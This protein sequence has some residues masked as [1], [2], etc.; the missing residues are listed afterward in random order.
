MDEGVRVND[1]EME[2]RKEV[3]EEKL[4]SKGGGVASAWLGRQS[5][6]R[7]EALNPCLARF[8]SLTSLH[9]RQHRSFPHLFH[10][11]FIHPTL[12]SFRALSASPTSVL[13]S[14]VNHAHARPA[15][16]PR[17]NQPRPQSRRSTSARATLLRRPRPHHH[18]LRS[19]R[20]PRS[21]LRQVRLGYQL[22]Q[23]QRQRWSAR[24][25]H[26]PAGSPHV[27]SE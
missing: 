18:D 14:Y 10:K 20:P 6:L 22:W 7:G 23:R 25:P 24:S 27:C 13:G 5:E 4:R 11:L 3:M 9:P 26:G 8:F 2:R 15:R 12:L 17:P 19:L 16:A 1:A 21:S